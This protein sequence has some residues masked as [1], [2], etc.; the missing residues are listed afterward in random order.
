[1]IVIRDSKGVVQNIGEWESNTVV[2]DHGVKHVFNP[3]PADYVIS[4][5]E[6]I[7]RADGARFVATDPRAY[8]EVT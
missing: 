6:V 1:M 5:E 8:E 2:D 7:T 4:D 3:M